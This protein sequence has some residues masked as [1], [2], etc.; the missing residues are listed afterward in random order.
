MLGK[1]DQMLD[2]QEELTSRIDRIRCYN[3]MIP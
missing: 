2:K 3:R 1:Q